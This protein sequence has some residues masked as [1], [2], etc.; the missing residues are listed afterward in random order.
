VEAA[1]LVT[2]NAAEKRQEWIGFG[3]RSLGAPPGTAPDLVEFFVN[4]SVRIG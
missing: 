2:K 3:W 1:R 4:P